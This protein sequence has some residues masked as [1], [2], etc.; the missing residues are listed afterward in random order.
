MEGLVRGR[1]MACSW[2]ETKS[3]HRVGNSVESLHDTA[4]E[5]C[6]TGVDCGTVHISSIFWKK[7]SI[8]FNTHM[9]NACVSFMTNKDFPFISVQSLACVDGRSI[10]TDWLDAALVSYQSR[11]MKAMHYQ[12]SS[13]NS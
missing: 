12:Y 1:V 2:V 6:F 3:F 11:D 10:I 7:K 5:G 9:L 4:P 13:K 8:I